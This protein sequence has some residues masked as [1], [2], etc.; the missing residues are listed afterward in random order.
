MFRLQHTPGR[1]AIIDGKEYLF[2]SGYAYLGMQHVPGFA[3]LVKEGMDK[4]GWLFPSSR[5]SNT[6]LDLFEAFEARL[7]EITGMEASVCFSSGFM[8]GRAV[9]EIFKEQN[10]TAAPGTHPAISTEKTEY[11]SIG[12]WKEN[13]GNASV[14]CLD[15][16]NPLTA[17][18]N[19]LAFLQQ[20]KQG[21]TCIIDDSHGAGLINNGAGVA[22][23]L[24]KKDTIN[25]IISFSL[26]KS[27]GLPGGAVCCSKSMAAQLRSTSQYTASTSIAPTFAYTF[28]NAQELYTQQRKKL[29]QNIALF[30]QLTQNRFVSDPQLPVF[31]LPATITEQQL[32]KEN[33]IISSFAYPDPAGKKINRVVLNAL[34]REED[35]EYLAERLNKH[36]A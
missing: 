28:L 10:I 35:L 12:D 17:Q 26:S 20:T 4:Y 27:Y 25:Y 9:M 15:S 7:S 8:A 3:E 11:G 14:I 33:I 6:Q 13:I 21:I 31:I 34:H 23:S 29:Q 18:I 32:E 36:T 30:N 22:A 2:F 1:T 5:I 19:D 16:V 24:V